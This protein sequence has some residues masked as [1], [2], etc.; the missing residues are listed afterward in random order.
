M[1]YTVK[2]VPALSGVSVRTLHFYDETGL[3]KPT[4]VETRSPTSIMA[5]TELRLQSSKDLPVSISSDGRPSSRAIQR[6]NHPSINPLVGAW[7]FFGVGRCELAS[8]GD[9]IGTTGFI[10]P[11]PWRA[12]VRKRAHLG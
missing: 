1:A 9:K 8:S 6:I 5:V 11:R 4:Y 2:Q 12:T 7:A 3:L 10:H